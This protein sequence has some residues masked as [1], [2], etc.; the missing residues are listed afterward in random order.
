MFLFS[1]AT[2]LEPASPILWIAALVVFIVIEA[3][4]AGLASIWFAIGSVAALISAIFSAPL[5]LQLVWF[6]VI[7][8][9]SLILTRPLVK[10]HFT[11]NIVAT[12]SDAL[13]G[14][15]GIVTE[16]IDNIENVGAVKIDGK[17]WTARSFTGEMISTGTHVEILFIEG[18]KLIVKVSKL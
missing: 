13:I 5:W 11:A 4:T 10:K 7:S 2:F 17:I 14:K 6:F 12:N 16:D 9:A 8:I 18:V 3:A 1:L 15:V